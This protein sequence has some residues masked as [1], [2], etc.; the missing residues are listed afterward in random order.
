MWYL[1]GRSAIGRFSPSHVGSELAATCTVAR[2]AGFSV[3]YSVQNAGSF[4]GALT[5]GCPAGETR[6]GVF[7]V[8]DRSGQG[9]C[10]G[11]TREVSISTGTSRRP[12]LTS[13]VTV[14]ISSEIDWTTPV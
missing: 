13:T 9:Y 4:C 3:A 2:R 6:K 11:L 5:A 14:R 12:R 8:R 7:P 1:R 10:A